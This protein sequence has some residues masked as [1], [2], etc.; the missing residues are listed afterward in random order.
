MGRIA[1]MEQNT[2]SLS[3][4]VQTVGWEEE[5]ILVVGQMRP[6]LRRYQVHDHRSLPMREVLGGAHHRYRS[7]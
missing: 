7:R 5:Q 3:V 4:W 6:A 2:G 1:G